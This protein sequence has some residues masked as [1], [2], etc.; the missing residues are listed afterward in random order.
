MAFGTAKVATGALVATALLGIVQHLCCILQQHEMPGM[1]ASKPCVR[2]ALI[3]WE[4]DVEAGDGAEADFPR[5]L[6]RVFPGAMLHT[7]RVLVE[8]PTEAATALHRK[9]SASFE[10]HD[11]GEFAPGPLAASLCSAC[12]DLLARVAAQ[13]DGWVPRTLRSAVELDVAA[14]DSQAA[15]GQGSVVARGVLEG[16][17]S[18]APDGKASVSAL[19][20]TLAKGGHRRAVYAGQPLPPATPGGAWEQPFRVVEWRAQG[21]AVSQLPERFG[22]VWA[23]WPTADD[24]TWQVAELAATEAALDTASLVLLQASTHA[25]VAKF[26]PNP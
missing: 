26:L 15:S 14:P 8:E 4:M 3:S 21:D 1:S 19:W 24:W 10:L 16:R 17:G 22:A 23:A 18:G 20:W 7:A 25:D 2:V 9:W 11:G 13:A 12:P 6:A 5:T